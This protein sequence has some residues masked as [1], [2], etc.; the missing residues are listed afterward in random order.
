M[1]ED[2]YDIH[3]HILPYVDDGSKSIDMSRD[4]IRIAYE[5]GIRHIVLTPHYMIGRFELTR[6]EIYD[7]YCLFVERIQDEFPDIEFFFGREVFFGEEIS[8]KLEDKII[9]TLNDTDYVLVEFHPTA[10]ASYIAESLYK[11]ENSGLTPILAHIE[12][13][14]DLFNDVNM[15]EQIIESGAYVQVNASSVAGKLGNGVKR[16]IIKLMKKGFVH[17]VATDAHSNRSRAPYLEECVKYIRKKLGDDY[18]EM[19][20]T[21]NPRK[22]LKNEYI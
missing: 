17:F 2:Y 7:K 8:E 12:R 3:C 19:L 11:I 4:M 13:Y 1:R 10:A 6:E 5:N 9:S 18:V 14:P 21:D 22:M 15:V 16:Q 20:L